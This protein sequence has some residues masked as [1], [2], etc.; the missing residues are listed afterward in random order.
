MA[1]VI[2]YL[3]I[4]F[5]IS[6]ILSSL[7]DISWGWNVLA[8]IAIILQFVSE[9]AC[10]SIILKPLGQKL[11][12]LTAL[13]YTSVDLFY[14]NISPFAIGGM[15]AQALYMTKDKIPGTH[16]WISILMF[17]CMNK[18]AMFV[19]SAAAILLIP[20]VLH[21]DS[22]FFGVTLIY[23]L[24]FMV[25][26]ILFCGSSMLCP[27]FVTAVAEP[28]IKGLAKIKIIKDRDKKLASFAKQMK[29]YSACSEYIKINPYISLT[30]FTL[31]LVKRFSM[32]VPAYFAYRGLGLSG[33]SFTYIIAVQAIL[34]MA[35]ESFILP[36]AIGVYETASMAFYPEIFGKVL[37]VPALVYIRTVCYLL[38]VI[39]SGT[40]VAALHIK[41]SRKNLHEK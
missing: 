22:R 29:E 16:T 34:G 19:S 18:L 6:E 23:G 32:L 36:G 21:T 40:V 4:N 37:A 10:Y 14:T 11:S 13:K 24:L 35:L 2:I 5:N 27:G 7:A 41:M 15:P 17:T 38:V 1:G 33:V 31:C 25:A 28:I 26:I 30:V 39:A 20:G 8:I 9:G 12:F 3:F